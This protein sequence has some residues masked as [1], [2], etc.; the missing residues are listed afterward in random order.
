MRRNMSVAAIFALS[1][2]LSACVDGDAGKAASSNLGGGEG[3][4]NPEFSPLPNR[5]QASIQTFNGEI[6]KRE[7]EGG[8][9]LIVTDDGDRYQPVNLPEKYKSDGLEVEVTGQVRRDMASIGMAGTLFEI[10]AIRAA[11]DKARE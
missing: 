10:K 11:A 1:V 3:W 8:I 4:R 6:R 2:T 7:I 5:E 9:Y